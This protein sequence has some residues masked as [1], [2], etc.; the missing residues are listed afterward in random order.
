[1]NFDVILGEDI[2]S[3]LRAKIDLGERFLS[4]EGKKVP[5]YNL[6]ELLN[7]DIIGERAEINNV[8]NGERASDNGYKYILNNF[9][10]PNELE[11]I[12]PS[13]YNKILHNL[14]QDYYALINFEPRVAIGY[15]HKLQVDENRKNKI[16][17]KLL[18]PYEGPFIINH[19]I[20]ENTYELRNVDNQN[21]RG[22][23][24]VE[25]LFHYDPG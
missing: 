19:V 13:K 14:L 6:N 22:K 21:I 2:L 4:I 17:I 5:I 11:I 20:N 9:A 10:Q 3:Q 1:M 15:V 18:L 23:F 16:C 7:N 8:I 12:C 24:H 25:M